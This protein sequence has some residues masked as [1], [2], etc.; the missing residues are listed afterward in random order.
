MNRIVPVDPAVASGQAKTLLDGVKAKVGAVPNLFR[1]L[2]Q[3]PTALESYL[4]VGAALAGGRFS[5][6]LREQIA[7]TVAECNQCEY[8]LSAHT[9]IG[10]KLG[11]SDEALAQA[12]AARA[13]D[14]RTDAILTLAR[15]IVVKRGALPDADIE[16]ARLAGLDDADVIETIANVVQNIFSNYVN[17]VAGTPVDFPAVAPGAGCAATA[18][19]TA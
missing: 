13:S 16:R 2:A 9:F 5:G 1:V 7:L 4:G 17:H 15:A 8:C 10:R 14:I 19:I 3:A 6:A 12:R 18:E 11:L